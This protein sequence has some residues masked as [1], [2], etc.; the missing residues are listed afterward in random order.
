MG[1][2]K[3]SA[4][5]ESVVA[6]SWW[7]VTWDLTFIIR[8]SWNWKENDKLEWKLN[9]LLIFVLFKVLTNFVTLQVIAWYNNNNNNKYLFAWL[10]QNDRDY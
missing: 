7:P 3:Y 6:Q 5:F 1:V 9:V 10:L 8:K 2:G 4:M